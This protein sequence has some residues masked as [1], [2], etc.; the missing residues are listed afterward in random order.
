MKAP[1][2]IIIC[3]DLT[4]TDESIKEEMTIPTRYLSLSLASQICL[5]SK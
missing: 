4:F 3:F 5:S 2:Q 1:T